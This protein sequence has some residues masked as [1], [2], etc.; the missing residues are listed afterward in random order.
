MVR[1]GEWILKTACKEIKE[2]HRKGFPS[3]KLAVNVSVKQFRDH[4]FLEMV[5]EVLIET[6]LDPY[7]LELEITESIVQ[8][9]EE[10]IVIINKL[11]ALGIKIAI[12]DFGTGY[13]SLSVLN[14]LPI[15]NLK[16]DKSFIKESNEN[17]EALVKTII[18]MGRNLNFILVAEGV[19]Y[20]EQ[21]TF[22]KKN[23][24]H[25]GQ[26]YFFSEPLPI[27]ELEKQLKEKHDFYR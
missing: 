8:D 17:G 19:E 5:N 6:E 24:C 25:I 7:Y 18:Q 1:I 22:S 9:I 12:D 26:G 15:D 21:V 13:S 23:H 11:K 16:I 14:Q 27:E 10:S 4:K 20:E 2:L 3:I